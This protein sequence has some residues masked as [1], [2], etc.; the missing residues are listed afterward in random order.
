MLALVQ[1][2][3][4]R[5]RRP[6]NV[7]ANDAGTDPEPARFVGTRE[8]FTDSNHN[9]IPAPTGPFFEHVG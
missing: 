7:Y 9:I 2:T 5:G 3:T 4:G 8:A 1:K 6:K